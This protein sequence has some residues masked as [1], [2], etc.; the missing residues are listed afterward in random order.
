MSRLFAILFAL[1][2][3]EVSAE[4]SSYT[5]V[6]A[7]F[8]INR[9]QWNEYNRGVENYL[10]H[11]TRV[12]SLDDYMVIYIEPEYVDFV[13][14]YREKYK[15]KTR[16]I[17]LSIKDLPYYKYKDQIEAIM[18]DPA[19]KNGLADPNC[20][21]V[22]K[23]LYDVIMWSKVPLVMR[24][25]EDN[26]FHTTHFVWLDFGI[27]SHMLHD[28]MLNQP[29]LK[30]V[31]DKI[32]FLC[33]SAPSPDDL[34]I[35]RFFKSHTNRFAGSMFTGNAANFRIFNQYLDEEIQDCLSKK[36]VDC[37]QSLFSITYLKHPELFDLYVGD[38]HQVICNY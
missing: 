13:K 16:I 30:N 36:V 31:P 2:I 24:T 28:N 22:T 1:L 17:P 34:D 20:P 6:T 5:I 15:E 23:P 29:L 25:V 19:F 32:K 7:F 8:N 3:F 33:R 4:E 18:E 26:P 35:C 21:E 14:T 12:F 10:Y 9:G 27:H 11:A 38:W 37:D